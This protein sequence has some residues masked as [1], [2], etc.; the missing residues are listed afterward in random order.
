M[1]PSFAELLA[2]LRRRRFW[3]EIVA[4]TLVVVVPAVLV[5]GVAAQR[6]LE[7]RQRERQLTRT[8]TLA[9]LWTRGF[10]SATPAE[11]AAWHRSERQVAQR[12]I[13]SVD[14][15]GLAQLVT[16]RAEE[17]GI[18]DV[19]VGFV[20]ADSLEAARSRSVGAWTFDLAPY[21]LAVEFTTSYDAV[22]SYVGSLPP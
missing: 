21:A 4:A 14:R 20:S 19:G 3:V 13:R 16:Q 1:K 6:T 10:Q 18:P 9:D 17:L 22:L 8:M 12:G 2:G 15:V 7:L 11:S 5:A